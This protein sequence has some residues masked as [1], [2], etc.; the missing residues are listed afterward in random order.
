MRLRHTFPERRVYILNK[1]GGY[2]PLTCT[3]EGYSFMDGTLFKRTYDVK[4]VEH[5]IALVNGNK[6][7]VYTFTYQRYGLLVLISLLSKNW[8]FLLVVA[9]AVYTTYREKE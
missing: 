4:P 9:Y 7:K 1:L 3:P 6:E 8:W 5:G 2:I